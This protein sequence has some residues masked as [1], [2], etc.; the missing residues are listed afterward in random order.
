MSKRIPKRKARASASPGAKRFGAAVRELSVALGLKP[1]A[2]RDK[3]LHRSASNLEGWVKLIGRDRNSSSEVKAMLEGRVDHEARR[4]A[5]ER[6]LA[7]Q[8]EGVERVLR[9]VTSEVMA[10]FA[11]E[12]DGVS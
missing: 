5:S 4:W 2:L 1:A 6:A 11:A 3:V 10:R 7:L 8:L 12:R 9:E